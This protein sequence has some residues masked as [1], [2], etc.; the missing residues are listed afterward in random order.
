MIAPAFVFAIAL[1]LAGHA[2]APSG[3]QTRGLLPDAACTPGAVSTTS[4]DVVCGTAT[5]GRRKVNRA[6]RRRVLHAYGLPLHEEPGAYEIDHLVP[7]ELGGSNDFANLWPEAAPGFHD[8]D[9]VEDDLHRRVCSGHLSLV[10]A[11]A[12]IA[13]D[14]T[15][16]R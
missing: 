13:R 16:A 2:E 6:L 15:T 5:R 8:K 14:W 1:S 12:A 3:C 4:L 7:L 11:Q 9:R 10:A